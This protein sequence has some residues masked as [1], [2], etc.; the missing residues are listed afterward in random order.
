MELEEG[1]HHCVRVF[2]LYLIK[3]FNY[4]SKFRHKE[5]HKRSRPEIRSQF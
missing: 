4:I 1:C 3:I 5:R 2:A